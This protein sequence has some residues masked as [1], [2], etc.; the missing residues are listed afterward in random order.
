MLG[1]IFRGV[2]GAV[3][4]VRRRVDGIEAQRR[5]AAV[6]DVV[7]GAGG[8]E[9]RVAAEGASDAVH[10]LARPAEADE[11]AALFD[12]QELVGIRVQLDSDVSAD[13]YRHQRHLQVGACP[14]RFAEALVPRGLA[15][16]VYHR[17]IRTEIRGLC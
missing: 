14:Y 3:R 1:V 8:H 11:R 6:D 7:P 9:Y 15:R 16:D 2:D 5:P 17:R 10:F 12:A 13:G 4:M